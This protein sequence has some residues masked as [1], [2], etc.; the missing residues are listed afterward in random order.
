[1]GDM[2]KAERD[3]YTLNLADLRKIY[4]IC[5]IQ[6]QISCTKRILKELNFDE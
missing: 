3:T 2:L 1:M 4:A 5:M 6:E